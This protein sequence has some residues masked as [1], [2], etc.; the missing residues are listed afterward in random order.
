MSHFSMHLMKELYDSTN[1]TGI[2]RCNHLSV[3]KVIAGLGLISRIGDIRVTFKIIKVS[4][5]LKKL[6]K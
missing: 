6:K 2:I 1:Q 5:T 4:G 3:S